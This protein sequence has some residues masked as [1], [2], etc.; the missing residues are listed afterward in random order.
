M[1]SRVTGAVESVPPTVSTAAYRVV[2]E[3]LTNTRRHAG[4][5]VTADLSIDVG[6]DGALCVALVAT[7]VARRRRSRPP[8]W[9]PASD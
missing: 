2:Q 9:V 3:A 1:T 4:R 7:T 5:G 6:A 8:T